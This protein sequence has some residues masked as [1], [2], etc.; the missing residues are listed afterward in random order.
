MNF[1]QSEQLFEDFQ[2]TSNLL[3]RYIYT[4]NQEVGPELLRGQ[5]RI[6]RLLAEEDGRSQKELSQ[7]MHIRPASLSELLKKLADKNFVYSTTNEKDR[8][9][10]NYWLT[11]SGKKMAEELI[12]Q[13]RFSGSQA[14]AILEEEE[15]VVLD[16][17]LSKIIQNLDEKIER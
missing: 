12:R 1:E 11:S 10:T 4:M 13:R 9:I 7:T 8:R 17:I 14:F 3:R 15:Q 2:R 5:G 6:L 16:R